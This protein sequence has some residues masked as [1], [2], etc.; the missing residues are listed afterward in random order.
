MYSLYV[1]HP[2]LD[3]NRSYPQI[4]G[5]CEFRTGICHLLGSLISTAALVT[6]EGDYLPEMREQGGGNFLDFHILGNRCVESALFFLFFSLPS[7]CPFKSVH[8]RAAQLKWKLIPA[9]PFTP[10]VGRGITI[11]GS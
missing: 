5:H 4:L 2:N 3:A 10:Q 1:H 7:P 8:G 6:E 9:L 11:S